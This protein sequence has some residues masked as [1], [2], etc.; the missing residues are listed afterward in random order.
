MRQIKVFLINV[1]LQITVI[2]ELQHL[3][4]IVFA[5]GFF[6]SEGIA[7]VYA[8]ENAKAYML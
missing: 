6:G 1:K 2:R 5:D 7:V 3:G 4:P 8:V